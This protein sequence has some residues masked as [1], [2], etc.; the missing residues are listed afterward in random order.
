MVEALTE[1]W[2]WELMHAFHPKLDEILAKLLTI[3]SS[4]ELY[5]IFCTKMQKALQSLSI[6]NDDSIAAPETK[7]GK[8]ESILPTRYWTNIAAALLFRHGTKEQIEYAIQHYS[9]YLLATNFASI[10]IGIILLWAYF[11][12]PLQIKLFGV[13]IFVV[14]FYFLIRYAT[15][16]YYFA[17]MHI[18]RFAF[19]LLEKN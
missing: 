4:L 14:V 2:R 1:V 18:Y 12:S 16:K 19:Y 5:R 13:V 10:L 3:H 17:Y 8:E 11:M 15:D 7:Q 9:M 6:Y